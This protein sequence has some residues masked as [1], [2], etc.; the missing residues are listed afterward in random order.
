MRDDREGEPRRIRQREHQL[1]RCRH[2]HAAQA[3]LARRSCVPPDVPAEARQ[4]AGDL[5]IQ[6]DWVLVAQALDVRVAMDPAP[7]A[8]PALRHALGAHDAV[9]AGGLP[10]GR[11]RRLVV[12]E[13]QRAD[14]PAAA[15]AAAPQRGTQRITLA[16][17]IAEVV[18][19]P[20]AACLGD[21]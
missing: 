3:Q 12:G 15:L 5:A 10:N 6:G 4:R 21:G 14:L 16:R 17:L 7:V 11:L 19:A 20:P 9:P 1:R 13:R 2:L 18:E 8:R